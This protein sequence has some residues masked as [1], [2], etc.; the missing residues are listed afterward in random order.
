MARA[1]TISRTSPSNFRAIHS[2]SSRGYRVQENPALPLTRFSP[3]VRDAMLN[4]FRLTRG[5]F[6]VKWISQTWILSRAF[7]RPYRSTR[8]RLTGTLDQLSGL[9]PRSMTTCA[10]FLPGPA[11]PIVRTAASQFQDRVRNK[12]STKFSLGP[13]RPNSWF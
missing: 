9:S 5:N 3:R 2:S 10:F 6:S 13:P 11:G 12:S 7:H 1:N 8:S 4:L